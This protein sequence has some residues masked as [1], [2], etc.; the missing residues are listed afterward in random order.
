MSETLGNADRELLREVAWDA[1]RTRLADLPFGTD[2]PGAGLLAEPGSAF[3]TL[4]KRGRL[5]GCIGMIG[6][7]MPLGEAVRQAALSVIRDPRFPPLTEAELGDIE[8]SISWLSPFREVDSVTEVTVGEHGVYVVDGPASALL[9]PRVAS[10]RGWDRE[11]LLTEVC[12]KAGLSP[13]RWK[14]PGLTVRVFTALEF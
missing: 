14:E 12:R 13:D 10:D 11:R 1:I 4:T 9:L 6:E 2:L 5:R 8:L 7:R 3:V